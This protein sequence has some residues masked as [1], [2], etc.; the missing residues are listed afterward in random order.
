MP[1]FGN[2]SAEVV[3]EFLRDVAREFE[4]L[5]LIVANR[6]VGRPINENVGRHKDGIVEEPDRRILPVLASLFFKLGHAVEPTEPR[7]TIKDPGELRM[8]RDPALVE[9]DVGFRI[10]AAGEKG[11]GHLAGG[12]PQLF[13]LV[14]KRHRM[15][16]DDAIDARMRLLHL[17]EALDRA[18]IVA[19]VEIACR[20]NAREHAFGKLRHRRP[21]QDLDFM[22]AALMA[23]PRTAR[24]GRRR[25]CG[26]EPGSPSPTARST[27]ISPASRSSALRKSSSSRPSGTLR[28]AVA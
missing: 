25:R 2:G 21:L 24:K 3:V 9:D 11:R 5:L 20:L 16:V 26:Q 15:K 19:E 10:D 4:M 22:R 12:A 28:R 27:M 1:M 7:H 14:R 8:L 23:T 13:G 6:N 18:K 17:D